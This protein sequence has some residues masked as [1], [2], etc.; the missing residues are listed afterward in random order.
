MRRLLFPGGA[1]DALDIHT[2][3]AGRQHGGQRQL[4]EIVPKTIENMF[5]DAAVRIIEVADMICT[6]H[7]V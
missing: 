6:N 2:R 5:K 4:E 3:V 7:H 1:H